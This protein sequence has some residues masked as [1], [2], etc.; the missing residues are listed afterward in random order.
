MTTLQNLKKR[1]LSFAYQIA[2]ADWKKLS[3]MCSG[4]SAD[5]LANGFHGKSL[6][7]VLFDSELAVDQIAAKLDRLNP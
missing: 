6:A 2:V 3:A 4:Q 1:D 7:G 5:D